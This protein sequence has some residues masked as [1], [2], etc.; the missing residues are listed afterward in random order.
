MIFRNS[1]EQ[2]G[3][4]FL[5]R[6]ATKNLFYVKNFTSLLPMCNVHITDFII[7]LQKKMMMDGVRTIN[8]SNIFLSQFID[9][10]QMCIPIAREHYLVYIYSGEL[11]VNERGKITKIHSGECVFIRKDNRVGITKQPKNGEQFKSIF[12]SFPRKFLREFYQTL[13]KKQLP[14]DVKRHK[15]SLQKLPL[16]PDITSLF[17]SMTPYFNSTIAPTPELINL[18]MMEG[19]Y[20]LLNTDKNFYSSLFDFT[21]PWKIDIFNFLNEN[22]MYDLSMEEIA[23]F[24]GR[25]LASFKRDFKKIS[26]LPPQKWLIEKRLNV[27]FDKIRNER[28]KASD[29]CFEVGF[30]TL[31]HFSKAFKKQFGYPPTRI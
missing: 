11:E 28:R 12:L 16:R 15:I 17:E 18:K 2:Y 24:T 3:K 4:A 7:P 25:S 9:N 19:V 26:N 13:D 1:G 22:Y 8:Y 5:S 23:S 30:K 21:E 10:A 6:R 27:A 29:V 20:A 14:E 31:T